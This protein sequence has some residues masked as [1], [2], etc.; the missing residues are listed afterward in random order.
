MFK[1]NTDRLDYGDILKP[2]YGYVLEKAIGTTYSLDL[3]ALMANAISL[4]LAEDTDS[5]LINNP[6]GMLNALHKISDKIVI[7]CE[8]GQI[9]LPSS[10]NA[11]CLL[12]EK[13]IVPVALSKARGGNH[14]PAFHPKTWLLEYVNAEGNRSYRFIV[15]SRNLTFDRSWDISMVLNSS[16]KV[17]QVRKTKPIINFLGYLKGQVKN[18]T[19]NARKKRNMIAV[20]MNDLSKVSFSLE[21]KEFD[22]NFEILPLGIGEKSYDM[23]EDVLFCTDKNSADSTFHELVIMSPFLSDSLIEAWNRNERGLTNCRRTLITRKSELTK[24]KTQQV[25]NF[26]IYTLKDNIVDGEDS[27]SDENIVK[28]KQDIHAKIFLRRKYSETDLYLGSM[29]ASTSAVI[30]NVEMMIWLGTKNRYLNGESFLK[31]LFGGDADN[32]ANPFELSYVMEQTE[33]PMKNEQDI[34]EQQ[35]KTIC[36]LRMRAVVHE[37][38]GKYDI[39]VLFEN[40]IK[41]DNIFIMPLRSKKEEL[42]SE[43]VRFKDL[44]ILHLSEFYVIKII[45]ENSSIERVIMIPTVG[46]PEDRESAVVNSV[47]NNKKSFVEYLSFVLGDDY[48]LSM[49]EGKQMGESGF[50]KQ[51]YDVMPALYEKMLKTA[52]EAPERLSEINYLLKMVTNEDIIPEDFRDMYETFKSICKIK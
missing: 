33:D 50:Y 32:K 11:L 19:Q 3:E 1:I 42:I 51:S 20:L 38:D 34:M 45:G 52:L 47:V 28:Q 6:I 21:S 5:K 27:L 9:K 29:N 24:L 26:D 37:H 22:E 14:Y 18:T 17:K 13:M 44:D 49:L 36:R 41:G 16:K 10:H 4:G 35:I 2:P 46:F 12:L 31:D 15:M 25:T 43:K 30:R 48:I 8:A 39:E 40:P 7:F 23:K